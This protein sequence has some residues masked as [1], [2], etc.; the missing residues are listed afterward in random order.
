[1]FP[2]DNLYPAFG[3]QILNWHIYQK[4]RGGKG[5]P[6]LLSL[7]IEFAQVNCGTARKAFE[8]LVRN[9]ESLRTTF[10]LT[11]EGLMQVVSPYQ[12]A[13]HDLKTV[14]CKNMAQLGLMRRVLNAQA[15]QLLAQLET[16]PLFRAVLYE[17]AGGGYYLEC[18][19]H[20][21]ISDEWSLQLMQKELLRAYH[22][23]ESGA[24]K[25]LPAKMQLKDHGWRH[26]TLNT[27]E[28]TGAYWSEKLAGLQA[29][30]GLEA[31]YATYNA[32]L[33]SGGSRMMYRPKLPSGS[34]YIARALEAG[35][36]HK[37]LVYAGES[38]SAGVRQLSRKYKTTPSI[39]L[40]SSYLVL[41]RFL[42]RTEQTLIISRLS[43]R[44]DSTSH[45]LIGNFTCAVYSYIRAKEMKGMADIVHTVLQ[46]FLQSLDHAVYNPLVMKDVPLSTGCHL[47]VNM[48]PHESVEAAETGNRF[49]RV[50]VKTYFPIENTS[51]IGQQNIQFQW[52]YN[53]TLFRDSMIRFIAGEHIRILQE[54]I[55]AEDRA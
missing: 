55:T 35:Y 31:L 3:K 32:A 52:T 5:R 27:D 1:M 34:R 41:L 21:I 42:F 37:L 50:P 44:F 54:M 26:Y 17:I 20:H 7:T 23:I 29:G 11:E 10:R 8:I 43:G 4:N 14:S 16:G 30:I 53:T 38:I 46:E 22:S 40:L 51:I 49:V 39:I 25:P 48:L 9:H 12:A 33:N 15:E 2:Q 24:G 18:L 36:G 45:D 13:D 6:N 47:C 28:R 19:I